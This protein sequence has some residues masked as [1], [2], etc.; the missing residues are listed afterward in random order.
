MARVKHIAVITAVSAGVVAAAG[1]AW[2]VSGNGGSHHAARTA[3]AGTVNT[4]AQVAQDGTAAQAATASAR[5]VASVLRPGQM[6]K[7]GQ[8]LRSPN[9]K[10]IL[11]Q[12][13]DG[14]LVLYQGRTALWATATRQRGAV[15]AM[16]ADGNLVV[17]GAHAKALWAANAGVHKGATLVLQDD[18]NLVIYTKSGK[19][20]W[21][22]GISVGTLRPG[23]SLRPGQAVV[24]PNRQYFLL[25][26]ADGNLVLYRGSLLDN[27]PKQ[28]L[29][30]SVTSTPGSFA[31]MQTDGNFVVYSPSNSPLW[32]AGPGVNKGA[33]L[34]VQD[35]GNMVIYNSAGK[36]VWWRGIVIGALHAGRALGTA[37]QSAGVLVS[38]NREYFLDMQSDGNL[39]LY[40]GDILHPQGDRALWSSKTSSPGAFAE[41]QTDGNLVV[42]SAANKPLWAANS[43]VHSN[44][45]LALQNDGNLVLYDSSLH[46]Y[47][48]TGT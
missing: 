18:G 17:Y 42:Y 34:A 37:K 44:A 35:D 26:Q 22:R 2:A 27:K 25:M 24:S 19:P 1:G 21:W 31:T 13:T 20:V 41:M 3:S 33:M 16:Q 28:A 15:T 32:A 39:V 36:P 30:S 5:K 40:K 47:W 10:Y 23:Y 48:S 7:P 9:K 11:L 8:Y 14:N 38:P 29:W 46:P 6:L 45:M 4:T 12:Q 43:G